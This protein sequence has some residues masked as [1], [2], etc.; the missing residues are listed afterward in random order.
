MFFISSSLIGQDTLRLSNGNEIYGEI[1]FMKKAVLGIETPYSDDDFTIEWGEITKLYSTQKYL[2]VLS[3]NLRPV[4]TVHSTSV[5]GEI[6]ITLE[7]G[8]T[9]NVQMSKI[10]SLETLKSSF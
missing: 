4:G 6:E 8:S 10:T 3:G 1:K 5:I 2:I 9:L 7:D